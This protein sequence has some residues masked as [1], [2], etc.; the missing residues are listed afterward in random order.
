MRSLKLL[1]SLYGLILMSACSFSA[2]RYV[3][4]SNESRYRGL[5]PSTQEVSSELLIL[6]VGF[7]PDNKK[8]EHFVIVPKPGIDGREIISRAVL[9]QGTTVEI[10]GVQVCANCS[11]T[12]ERFVVE[13]PG[14]EGHVP[15]Y[16]YSSAFGHITKSRH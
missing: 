1:V 14:Y 9:K 4:A 12:S 13:V 6:G 8:V 15:I 16:L 10:K 11:G 2:P 3:D 5:V 7:D